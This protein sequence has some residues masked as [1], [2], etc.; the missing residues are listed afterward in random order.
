MMLSAFMNKLGYAERE[1][2]MLSGHMINWLLVESSNLEPFY[3][4]MEK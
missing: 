2:G 4:G 1:S 3:D